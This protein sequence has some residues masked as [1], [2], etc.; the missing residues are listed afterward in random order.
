MRL[1]DASFEGL[2]VFDGRAVTLEGRVRNA[3]HVDGALTVLYGEQTTRTW[4]IAGICE[5]EWID[6]AA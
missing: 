5:I 1:E 6:G 4:P 2:V 3:T